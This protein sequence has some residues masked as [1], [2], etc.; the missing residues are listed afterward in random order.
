MSLTG[1]MMRRRLAAQRA[2]EATKVESMA[3][4]KPKTDT[5]VEA[6]LKA[7]KQ[8]DTPIDT[9]LGS[10]I[11]PALVD[12]A[13]GL[14]LQLGD[15]VAT[16]HAKSGMTVAEWNALVDDDREARLAEAI[17]ALRAEAAAKG[18]GSGTDEQH[19][20]TEGDSLDT[21]NQQN[22]GVTRT[23]LAADGTDLEALT[24]RQIDAR[25]KETLGIELDGRLS[26]PGLIAAYL[27]AEATKVTQQ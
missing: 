22:N 25:A 2:E 15:V 1:H 27:A 23:N 18:A 24:K 17:E 16:A 3:T 6:A 21:G 19:E 20:P 7:S 4:P 11:L 14:Q 8:A 10:N 13:E 26:K 12:V 9:L 5:A